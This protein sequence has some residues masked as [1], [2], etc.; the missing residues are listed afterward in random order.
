MCKGPSGF[1][2][3]APVWFPVERFL[4]ESD[5]GPETGTLMMAAMMS[6]PSLIVPAPCSVPR[7]SAAGILGAGADAGP[8][9]GWELRGALTLA[10]SVFAGP[11][12]PIAVGAFALPADAPSWAASW[13]DARDS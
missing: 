8:P 4:P 3:L 11:L 12:G 6:V 2:A 1:R 9:R 7:S 13:W 10:A 5:G